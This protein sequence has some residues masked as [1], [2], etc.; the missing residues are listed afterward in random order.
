M[1]LTG[2]LFIFP[3]AANDQISKIRFFFGDTLGAFYIVMGIA[4]LIVSLFLSFS[5]YGSIVLGEP[6]EKPKYSFFTWGSMVFTCGLAADILF[7]SFSEWMMYADNPHV[8]SLEWAG[9][10]PLFHWSFIPWA[11]YLVLAV[12]FG[13]MLHVRK[14]NKQ[15]YSEACRPVIGKMA[16]GLL[17]RFI[18]MFALFA[19]F[20]SLGM[21]AAVQ[22][23]SAAEVLFMGWNVDHMNS[24]IM[25]AVA[26]GLVI[27]GGLTSLSRV[28]VFV[29]PFMIVFY[30]VSAGILL[31]S[32]W[33]QIPAAI[34]DMFRMAFS[35]DP[36]VF[37]GGVAGWCV[38]EAVQRGVARGVFSNE[39][40][41]GS[42]PM[43]YVTADCA[44][45]VQMGF[46]GIFEVFV[47]TF[48]ICVITG[49]AILVT[50]TMT[51]YPDL[52]GAQLVLSSFELVLGVSGKYIFA[53]ALL[54]FVTTTILGWYWYAETA[55]TYLFGV[56][57]KPV[58]KL[59]LIAMII[60]GASG[61]QLLWCAVA[62]RGR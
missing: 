38:M 57:F 11:F 25:M 31:L 40:G 28:T 24:G 29:V 48:V 27:I 23:N 22:A 39:A 17:G 30:L 34:G 56:R 8:E 9:V 19:L 13:F 43:A 4:V 1:G 35:F 6:G 32:H 3:A 53:I 16:E 51:F 20:A 50:G 10:Y 55:V 49:L 54:L 18:D 36:A 46:Y 47:D 58:M 15:R 42:A 14:R 7:Y 37:A 60:V 26:V 62:W 33:T 12:A 61:A 2:W 44:H 5:G 21:G 41:M 59:L 52:T 45:P